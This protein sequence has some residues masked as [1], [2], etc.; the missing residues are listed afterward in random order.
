MNNMEFERIKK[1]I[2]PYFVEIY[3]KEFEPL[4]VDR[5]NDIIPIFYTTIN[6]KKN[7]MYRN[8]KKEKFNLTL[9]FL[10]FNNVIIP[11]EIK[12]EASEYYNTSVFEK[13]PEAKDLLS[14]YF[15]N[16]SYELTSYYDVQ[17]FLFEPIDNKPSYIV[18]KSISKLNLLGISVT[19]DTYNDWLMTDEAKELSEK[20]GTIKNFILQL[21]NDYKKFDSQFD[22]LK[23]AIDK[24]NKLENVINEKYTIDF[25]QSI[26]CYMTEHDKKLFHNYM[27]SSSKDFFGLKRQLDITKIV[28]ENFCYD[29]LIEAFSDDSNKKLNSD[30]VSNYIKKAIIDNRVK[31]YKLIGVYDEQISMEEFIESPIAKENVP[32]QEFVDDVISKKQQFKEKAENELLTSLS[33]YNECMEQLKSLDLLD[34]DPINQCLDIFKNKV[35]C[36]NP[37]ARMENNVAKLVPILFF[38]PENCEEQYVDV[39]FIHEINHAIETV[40]LEYSKDS[41]KCKTGFEVLETGNE[42]RNY[43]RFSETINQLIAMSVTDLMH[44]EGVFLFD[45]PENSRVKGATSYEQQNVLI[46]NF[47]NRFKKEIML[48]RVSDNLEPLFKVVGEDNFEELNTVIKE[49][50]E[51]PYYKMMSAFAEGRENEF[52]QK[53]KSL[54]NRSSTVLNKMI[55][56]ADSMKL[57]EDNLSNTI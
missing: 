31:Y 45:S 46:T 7:E 17:K 14:I 18:N 52:T 8:Q 47:F 23:V 24:G 50:V 6:G 27:D 38:S 5:I 41:M 33:N 22:D 40:L 13:I 10:E 3:G 21:D 54:L 12:K 4:I 29:G 16:N 49:H 53:A 15:D 37:S 26:E 56:H 28:G 34:L 57:E 25:L 43:E 11:E 36:I 20:I 42:V 44:S 30:N 55:D 2:I 39:M 19:K 35:M 51:L 48:A 1:K 32:N 9:K